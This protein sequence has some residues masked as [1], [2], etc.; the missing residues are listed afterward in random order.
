M[1][2]LRTYYV[3][4]GIG[5]EASRDVIRAAYRDLA[6]QLHPDLAGD[7]STSAF[8]E[9]NEA[10][11]VL[12]DA[13]RRRAYDAELR[14]SEARLS[15]DRAAR[16]WR[17]GRVPVEPLIPTSSSPLSSDLVERMLDEWVLRIYLRRPS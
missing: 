3:V 11:E 14:T 4:L 13:D 5:R 16:D 1:R 8:Q 9:L 7:A 10:Y 12:G 6:K 17:T 15:R 2:A